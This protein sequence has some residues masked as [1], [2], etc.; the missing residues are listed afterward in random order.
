M[1]DVQEV[2]REKRAAVEEIRREVEALRLVAT[3]LAD[4]GDG[5]WDIRSHSA[6]I[7]EAVDPEV[8]PLRPDAEDLPTEVSTREVATRAQAISHKLK[9]IAEPFLV[10][11]VNSFRA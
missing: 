7:G 3:L 5:A 11:F 2:L 6:V 10:T 1:R 8:S 4:E 9:R